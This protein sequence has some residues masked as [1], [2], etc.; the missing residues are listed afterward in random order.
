MLAIAMASVRLER[1]QL[2][3]EDW[4]LESVRT[5]EF[6]WEAERQDEAMELVKK[7]P[8]D[9]E[10]IQP[11]LL[12]N[13]R[14]LRWMLATWRDLACR[15]R[16]TT[17]GATPRPLDEASR[18]RAFDL[19]G[20]SAERRE[21]SRDLDPP[22][23]I[24]A[25]AAVAAHQHALI[26]AKIAEIEAL[27]TDDLMAL[28]ESRR[29]AIIDGVSPGVDHQT[30]LDP[31]LRDRGP[32][33]QGPCL[34]DVKEPPGRGQTAQSR[35]PGA[36]AS[37]VDESSASVARHSIATSSPGAVPRRRPRPHPRPLWHQSRAGPRTGITAGGG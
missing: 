16:G 14:G 9:A 30:R 26:T 11:K 37:R 27:L 33:G 28:D 18:Q 4:R 6:Y 35:G 21:T 29:T 36:R 32:A 22:A 5:A 13:L 7:L 10:R 23:G 20:L 34:C 15:V 8:K 17:A 19:L 3:E 24:T 2:E 12:K 31:P 25:D 1:C